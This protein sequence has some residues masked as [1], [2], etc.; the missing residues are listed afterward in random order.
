[1]LNLT[2]M[3]DFLLLSNLRNWRLVWDL[4]KRDLK[5]RYLGSMMGSYWNFIHPLAMIGIY[6][7][8]FSKIMKIRL[9]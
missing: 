7:L 9:K 6:T 1:M 4:V 5:L 3:M 8:I 2:G